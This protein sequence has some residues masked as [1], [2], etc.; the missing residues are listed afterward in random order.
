M[1]IKSFIYYGENTQF[2]IIK[3]NK[4]IYI[5]EI[6]SETPYKKLITLTHKQMALKRYL[7]ALY[8]S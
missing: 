2:I 6:V 8:I 1:Y 4:N 3:H 7:S 5:Y